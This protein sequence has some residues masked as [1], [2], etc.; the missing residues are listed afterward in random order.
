[1]TV[2]LETPASR[3]TSLI[4]DIIF[5]CAGAASRQNPVN[6][7][8]FNYDQQTGGHPGRAAQHNLVHRRP[9]SKCKKLLRG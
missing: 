3:E 4:V 8:R 5:P 6:L 9:S 2:A 7:N 1:D